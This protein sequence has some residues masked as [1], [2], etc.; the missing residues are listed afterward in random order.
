MSV[1]PLPKSA[2][3]RPL[4][5][6]G[7]LPIRPLL[8]MASASERMGSS[9]RTERDSERQGQDAII[10]LQRAGA[11]NQPQLRVMSPSIASAMREA[12][13]RDHLQAACYVCSRQLGGPL[14]VCTCCGNAVHSHCA[15]AAMHQTVCERCMQDLQSAEQSRQ[16]QH[17]AARALGLAGAR[18]AEA[19]GTAVGAVSAAGLAAGQ[20]LVHGASAGARSAWSGAAARAPPALEVTHPRPASLPPPLPADPAS[21]S[22]A[23]CVPEGAEVAWGEGAGHS[24]TGPQVPGPRAA[25]SEADGARGDPDRGSG[26]S[27]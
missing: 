16:Q 15:L 13:I 26:R 6:P 10:P 2:T 14:V 18:G 7:F 22:R 20:F 11:A 27:R 17:A 24:P 12:V 25:A 21:S 8:G 3:Q 5:D 9:F 19:L 23:P 4:S 1:W